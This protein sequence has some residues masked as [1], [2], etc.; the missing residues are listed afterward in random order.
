M[1]QTHDHQTP[2]KRQECIDIA[3]QNLEKAEAREIRGPF[4]GFMPNE[5]REQEERNQEFRP[6]MANVFAKDMEGF[7]HGR[8]GSGIGS[9]FG[10]GKE[11]GA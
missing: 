10:H 9:C 7:A 5:S 2:G 6:V 3:E 8:L 11:D 4:S 1:N